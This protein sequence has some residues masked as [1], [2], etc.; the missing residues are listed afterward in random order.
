MRFKKKL[1]LLLILLVINGCATHYISVLGYEYCR[2][3]DGKML[4]LSQQCKEN[5]KVFID[6]VVRYVTPNVNAVSLWVDRGWDEHWY[7]L[8][9]IQSKVIDKG[10]TPIFFFYWFGGDISPLMVKQRRIDY[11]HDLE[12]LVRF[13]DQLNGEKIVILNPEFNMNGIEDY[14]PFNDLLMESIRLVK[15]ANNTKVSVC[16]GDF[17][18]YEK[19][20]D[21]YSWQLFHLSIHQAIKEVDFI[22]FQEMRGVTRNNTEEILKTPERSLKFATFLTEKYQKPTFLAYLALSSYGK[23]GLQLQEQVYQGFADL[24]PKFIEEGNLIGFNTFHLMDE[25]NQKG[26]FNEAEKHFGIIDS[27]GHPKPALKQF[28]KIYF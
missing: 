21:E 25:P 17:G 14:E 4:A 9:D 6:E 22:A 3:S 10:Y 8:L 24:M 5:K 12:K 1:G 13:I 18:Y 27:K 2:G 23:D 11:L 26:Y 20:S 16:I 15:Q 19:I 28:N 7:K